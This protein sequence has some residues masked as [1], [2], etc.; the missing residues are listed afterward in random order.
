MIYVECK[1]D[2]MLVRLLTK[3]PKREVIHEIKG[4]SGVVE[5]LRRQKNSMGVVDEDPWAVQPA[6]LSSMRVS[7]DQATQGLKL[8]HD[9][10]SDNYVVVLCPRLEEWIERATKETGLELTR[11]GLPDDPVRLHQ[12]INV[13]LSK[14]QRLVK[15]LQTKRSD[16]LSSLSRLLQNP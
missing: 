15:N 9:A 3:L 12:V 6:Y 10:S 2:E 4:K 8:L 1:P 7:Q 5:R 13:D 14:F 16:R 11:Y